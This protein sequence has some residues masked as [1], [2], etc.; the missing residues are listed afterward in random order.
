LQPS[1]RMA[2]T[3]ALHATLGQLTPHQTLF[4]TLLSLQ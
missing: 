1:W 2:D 3:G 4:Y